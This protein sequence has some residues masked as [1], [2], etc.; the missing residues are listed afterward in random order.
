MAL[1][2]LLGAGAAAAHGCQPRFPLRGPMAAL[3]LARPGASSGHGAQR[4]TALRQVQPL[5]AADLSPRPRVDCV[6]C[7]CCA[8]PVSEPPLAPPISR[9]SSRSDRRQNRWG[10][11]CPNPS[12]PPW[13]RLFPEQTPPGPPAATPCPHA[14]AHPTLPR[15]LQ[16][17]RAQVALLQHTRQGT[18]A[19][20]RRAVAEKEDYEANATDPVGPPPPPPPPHT[21]ARSKGLWAYCG[22]LLFVEGVKPRKHLILP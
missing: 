7:L 22:M 15:L 18:R 16:A 17:G 11:Q 20:R 3:V 5:L 8:A 19:V 13:P 4:P 21:S 10:Q 12:P 1:R 6:A 2:P 14:P 9:C